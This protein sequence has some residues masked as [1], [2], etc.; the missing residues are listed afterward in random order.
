MQI[1]HLHAVAERVSKI[2]A[3]F[4][5]EGQPVFLGDLI[6]NFRDLFFIAHD[7]AEV[8]RP[9]RIEPL[10]LEHG[11]KLVF[12]D[13]EKRIALALVALFEPEHVFVKRNRFREIVYFDGDV[14]DA[15]DA[16]A[17]GLL[18]FSPARAS[19]NEARSTPN[20]AAPRT[21]SDDSRTTT[22]P[23]TF[24]CVFTFSRTSGKALNT[25]PTSR[26]GSADS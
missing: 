16:N 11:E 8:A 2:A 20:R 12:A 22:G 17:H 19:L 26:A 18:G 4:R 15:V 1:D 9:I 14:V 13:L 21:H 3:K 7:D 10:D 25:V 23:V 24:S 5:N 6:A